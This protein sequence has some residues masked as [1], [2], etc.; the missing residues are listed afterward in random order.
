M[1]LD[2]E[3]EKSYV[4]NQSAYAKKLADFATQTKEKR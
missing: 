3:N 2:S 1:G 4:D